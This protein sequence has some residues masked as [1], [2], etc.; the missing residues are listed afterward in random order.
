MQKYI[1]KQFEVVE[2]GRTNLYTKDERSGNYVSGTN[3]KG[4]MDFMC[5]PNSRITKIERQPVNH[6]TSETFSIGDRISNNETLIHI[7]IT[8]GEV[9]FSIAGGTIVKLENAVK[10]VAPVPTPVA[11][12]TPVK[13]PVG[14]PKKTESNV[15]NSALQ[16]LQD[17][18]IAAYAINGPIRLSGILKKT[19]TKLGA[20]EF[21]YRFFTNWNM[22][23][24]ELP[25]I[26]KYDNTDETQCITGKRR[27]LGDLYMILRYYFPEITLKEVLILL[28]RTLPSRINPGFRTSKCS[29]IRKRV[30]YHWP[31][32]SNN[33][34]SLDENDEY[35][36]L[37]Q[38]YL[39]QINS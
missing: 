5:L 38:W 31:S 21:L 37:Y 23:N 32:N 3:I 10:Y 34:A 6:I 28:Y 25:K 8:L 22:T 16:T 33:I 29:T 4:L 15:Q 24:G 30:W 7:N 39:D 12:P 17:S 26:T 9:S 13:R 11:S 27:S 20:E 2:G 18:I 35:Q 14:R 1:I 36:H 19:A